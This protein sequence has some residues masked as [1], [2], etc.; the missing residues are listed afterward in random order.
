[1][2]Q[3]IPI[4][5]NW[6]ERLLAY[7]LDQL[8]VV[9]PIVLL[10][11]PFIRESASGEIIID[12]AAYMVIFVVNLAYHSYCVASRWQATLGMRILSMH[13]ARIDG[14]P[15]KMRD[16]I[17][18]FLAFFLPQLPSY[19]SFIPKEHASILVVFLTIYWFSPILFRVD[20][21]GMHDRLCG[22]RVLAGK[23]GL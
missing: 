16:A 17:E 21:M 18:R 9:L 11:Q 1:M 23:V 3:A 22:T 8:I 14:R 5:A 20:R 2:K 12:P 7:L 19:A 15:L 10:A 13:V 6:P 4:Y